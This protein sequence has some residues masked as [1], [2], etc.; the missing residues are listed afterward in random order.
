MLAVLCCASMISWGQSLEQ[1][2]MLQ[3]DSVEQFTP[4]DTLTTQAKKKKSLKERIR[5]H[6]EK[7]MAEPY[8]T[9]RNKGYWWRALKHGKVNFKDSTMGYPKFVKFCY[10]AYVWGDK[11]F[12][13]YD[14]SYVK[15]TGKNWKLILKSDNWDDSYIGTP[16]K[17]VRMV[18]NS[19]LVSNIG[20]SLSFMAVSV[21]YS[22]SVS[23][24]VHGGKLSNKVDFSFT[25]ARFAADA[26]Y[27]ENQN[28]INVT[29]TD[30]ATDNKEHKV[31]QSGIS[32]KAMGLTAYYFFNNRRYAQAAAYCFSKYQKRS[33]GSWLAGFS[34]QH[35]DVKF[36]VEKLP[37][38]A[39]QYIPTQEDAPRILYN[40]YCVLVGYAHNWVLG[41]KWLLNVTVTPYLG[42]RYNIIH[43]AEDKASSFS[44]NLR[45]R[46][47]A[48]YNHK[49][50][51]VGLQA[52][53][54]HHRYT[55]QGSRLVSSFLS[56]TALA[57]IR[58]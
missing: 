7:K 24:L 31:R 20:V 36:D 49:K 28:D 39:R 26:Y 53:A 5:Q 35:F 41:R 48:V 27:W 34:L 19:N 29:Y 44:L 21:G 51:F 14:T 37:D 25:C 15:S 30:K 22:V 17:D 46:I 32:R 4:L 38:V 18:M 6:I 50:Y 2:V 12:N 57:G 3:P 40:D 56:F 16:M 13:S 23:N 10:K 8:D 42:Y 33:A 55:T 11:A 54:D 52:N 47:G 45:A 58:F 43:D 9:T 1:T